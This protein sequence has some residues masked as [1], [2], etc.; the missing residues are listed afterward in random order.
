MKATNNITGII[1]AGGKSSRMGTDKGLISYQNKPFVATIIQALEP[2]VTDIILVSN[3][4]KYDAFK[5][6]RVPDLIEDSGPVAGIYTGLEF[7]KTT[8]NLVLSCD[9][10]LVKTHLLKRL[11][12]EIEVGYDVVQFIS[13]GKTTPLIALYKKQCAELFK[14]ELEN[15]EKRLQQV[16]NKLQV[17]TLSVLPEDEIY[18]KNI[19]TPN[20]LKEISHEINY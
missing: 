3:H 14:K 20:E 1:L 7:S 15:D 17:K 2:I 18:L 10:P 4:S 9:V 19:N 16:L 11:V 6:K 12:K 5:Y 8:Y 13:K